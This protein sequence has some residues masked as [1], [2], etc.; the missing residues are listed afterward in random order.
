MLNGKE[1]A[2]VK[3]PLEIQKGCLLVPDRPGIG[4]ELA[5]DA[6]SIFPAHDR[7]S[8]HAHMN[9]DGSVRDW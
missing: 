3:E 7:A 4:I 1:D 2:M 9:F 8:N 6:P 5:E